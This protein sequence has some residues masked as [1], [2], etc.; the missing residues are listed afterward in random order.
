[1]ARH[2]RSEAPQHPRFRFVPAD[3]T[4]PGPWQ[5]HLKEVDTVINLAGRPI[6]GRWT[7]A[8]KAEIRASRV[9]T[10]RHL[11]QAVPGGHAVRLISA[12]GAGYY[13]S[14]GDEVLT[15]EASAGHDFLAALSAEWEAAALAGA[16]KGMRVAVVRLGV[17]LDRGGGALAQ[18]I[19]AF[20]RFV[21]GP[22]G[23]GRQWFPW[24]HRNDLVSAL[25]FLAD[26]PELSGAFNGCAPEPVRNRDLAAALGHELNR[27][28]V[29]AAPAF[30]LR[31]AL[32]EFAEVLLAS[33]RMVPRRLQQHGFDFRYPDI[34]S[35]LH[36]ILA[37]GDDRARE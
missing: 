18:M 13:G 12:S 16:E 17:V 5:D 4:R 33:Q 37:S 27:P 21:G 28:A 26:H 24:V 1:M 30:I 6:F 19:P 10:T 23:N 2:A 7:V 15:E 36:A 3:T 9:L 11:V 34:R 25:L 32:G 35:A 14:R 8:L 20:R 22:L 29:L 31:A